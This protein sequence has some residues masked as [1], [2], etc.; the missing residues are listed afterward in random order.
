MAAV[1][2]PP[3]PFRAVS[4]FLFDPAKGMDALRQLEQWGGTAQQR[5][6]PN[7]AP[8]PWHRRIVP[9]APSRDED[10]FDR[11][12]AEARRR[13]ATA[14]IAEESSPHAWTHLGRRSSRASASADP[15]AEAPAPTLH[16]RP[17]PQGAR[18]NERHRPR[19][20]GAATM[21]D[22]VPAVRADRLRRAGALLCSRGQLG[23]LRLFAPVARP[24]SS[25]SWHSC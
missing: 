10:I 25:L 18:G 12:E 11:V 24:A 8:M 4:T 15:T 1:R 6:T 19:A 5:L 7:T 2:V 13:P 14:A 22:A 20:G 9:P 23:S 17:V 3:I 16:P 21:A